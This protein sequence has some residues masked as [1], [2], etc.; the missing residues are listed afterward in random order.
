[1]FKELDLSELEQWNNFTEEQKNKAINED[2]IQV[3]VDIE[4]KVESHQKIVE[5]H[6]YYQVCSYG[7]YRLINSIIVVK[8]TDKETVFSI[9]DDS[10]SVKTGEEKE[11]EIGKNP[12]STRYII[13]VS[14]VKF[15][16]ILEL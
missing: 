1:M 16:R 2:E 14:N 9:N 4:I 8:T 5:E 10:I 15:G 7:N 3:A 11:F 12:Y 6:K 13:K